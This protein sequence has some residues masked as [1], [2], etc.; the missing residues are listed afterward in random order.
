MSSEFW[1]VN[2]PAVVSEQM[3]DEVVIVDLIKGIYYSLQG[4]AATI[5][6]F[7]G[8]GFQRSE[9]PHQIAKTFSGDGVAVA[10]ENGKGDY[11]RF[12]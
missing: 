5:W 11:T 1:V 6:Q 3:E 7:I 2:S 12:V 8:G 9:T 10:R 4:T